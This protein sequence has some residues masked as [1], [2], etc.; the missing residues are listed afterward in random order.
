L[1]VQSSNTAVKVTFANRLMAVGALSSTLVSLDGND[2]IPGAHMSESDRQEYSQ[3]IITD[4]WNHFRLESPPADDDSDED[5]GDDNGREEDHDD[6]H[7]YY[8]SDDN[9][10]SSSEEYY[11]DS[12]DEDDDDGD[13]DDGDGDDDGDDED[14][15]DDDDG[16]NSQQGSIVIDRVETKK[17]DKSILTG[18]DL[19]NLIHI[20]INMNILTEDEIR[21]R[22][23]AAVAEADQDTCMYTLLPF[24]K[25][26]LEQKVPCYQL[27]ENRNEPD[28]ESICFVTQT[29]EHYIRTCVGKEPKKPAGSTRPKGRCRENPCTNCRAV[30]NFLA[31]PK[32]KIGQFPCGEAR[33]AHLD[34]NFPNTRNTAYDI[35]TIRTGKPNVWQMTKTDTLLRYRAWKAAREVAMQ[36]VNA[37]MDAG[38]PRSYLGKA[39]DALL[40]FD[41]AVIEKREWEAQNDTRSKLRKR[42]RSVASAADT[43]PQKE[44]PRPG[45]GRPRKSGN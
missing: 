41:V 32:K 19:A 45:R 18:T 1:L 28:P 31:D 22:L 16:D 40:S 4:L 30:H 29:V 25:L 17:Y 33:L 27:G 2:T 21:Q 20:T 36:R 35:D 11:D 24:V 37:L 44:S 12:D 3:Q 7:Y 6:D 43:T 38:P 42:T 15:D 10:R 13:D 9:Y 23:L 26:I 5:D 14:D 8:D 39:A 34:Q